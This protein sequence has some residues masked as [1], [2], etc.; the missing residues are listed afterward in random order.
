M[1]MIWLH[2][3]DLDDF[4]VKVED[5]YGHDKFECRCATFPPKDVK[6]YIQLIL[7]HDQYKQLEDIGVI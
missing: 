2:K 4:V 5:V 7:S 1:I 3:E 6:N